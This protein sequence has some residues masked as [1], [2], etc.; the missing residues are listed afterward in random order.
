MPVPVFLPTTLDSSEKIF[1]AIEEL[2][3]KVPS[4]PL[5][6]ELLTLSG[7]VVPE[8]DG[9]TEAS[10]VA[11][12]FLTEFLALWSVVYGRMHVDQEKDWLNLPCFD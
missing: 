6:T 1:A 10:D 9:K 8:G 12:E 5:E 3:G 4:N 11:S 7:M 2:R